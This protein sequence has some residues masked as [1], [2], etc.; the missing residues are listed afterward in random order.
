M[1]QVWSYKFTHVFQANLSSFKFQHGRCISSL[2]ARIIRGHIKFPTPNSIISWYCIISWV[3]LVLARSWLVQRL[4]MFSANFLLLQYESHLVK[5][6]IEFG[7]HEV[8]TWI[9]NQPQYLCIIL[10]STDAKVD[11]IFYTLC[12]T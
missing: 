12:S 9:Q 10:Y 4:V 8:Y 6:H 11:A 7:P 2:T 1:L 3:L 5:R